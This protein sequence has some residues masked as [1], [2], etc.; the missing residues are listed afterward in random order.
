[1]GTILENIIFN[2]LILS[3]EI[4]NKIKTSTKEPRQRN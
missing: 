1:M 3:D 4:E 2:K